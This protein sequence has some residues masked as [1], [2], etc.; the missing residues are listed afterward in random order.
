[1]PFSANVVRVLIASPGDIPQGRQVLRET[2]EDWNSLHA[3]NHNV[4][5]LPVMWE[6]DAVPQMGDRPQGIINRQLVDA[7]DILVGIFWTRLGTPTGEAES[8]T[9]EEIRR[10]MSEGKPVHLYFSDEP[11]VLDSVDLNEHARLVS[12]R[13]EVQEQG[14]ID[15]FTTMD[16]LRRKATI[17]LTMTVR[18]RFVD[19]PP[20]ESGDTSDWVPAPETGSEWRSAAGPGAKLLA[21]IDR[22]REIR[23]FSRSGRPQYTTRERLTIENH[24]L[25][26]AKNLSIEFELP[27]GQT[28]DLPAILSSDSPVGHLPPGGE[29]DYPLIRAMGMVDQW[30]VVFRWTESG[31]VEYELRQTLR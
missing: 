23:G 6:R 14:L 5:L 2:I 11:V 22:Q 21:R 25:E 1:M 10:F 27:E 7:A 9:A 18:E 19:T 12:F 13:E 31:G 29:I 26:A 17:A 16:E 30:D 20:S 15:R 24:G 4:M 8:G 28:G 3:E